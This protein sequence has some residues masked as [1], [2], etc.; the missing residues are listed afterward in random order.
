MITRS[1]GE[2]LF[3]GESH[4]FEDVS[5]AARA[6]GAAGMRPKRSI[7]FLITTGEE[8]GFL[9]SD[10]FAW[11][12]TVPGSDI[13]VNINV[14]GG[15]ASLVP[16]N[17]VVLYGE[18]HSTLGPVARRTAAEASLEVT[19]DPWPEE[20][21]FARQDAF[22]FVLKGIPALYVDVGIK[23][24]DPAIDGLAVLKKWYATVYHSPKDDIGQNLDFEYGAR[25]S[26]FVFRLCL[27]IANGKDRP[28]WNEGD[29]FGRT[30]GTPAAR[31]SPPAM[32]DGH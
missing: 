27:A 23:S 10:Y 8:A 14:D 3:A 26:R 31:L 13:A 17:D 20:V 29:F 6:L 25:F 30:F 22:P 1:G 32:I 7:L 2:V 19:P 24:L 15:G 11:H 5:Q 18:E 12:P 4:S 16:I 28:K 9:G 21:M